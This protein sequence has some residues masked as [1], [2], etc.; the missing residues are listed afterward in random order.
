MPFGDISNKENAF[1]GHALKKKEAAREK[2]FENAFTKA[3]QLSEK[4]WI[5][6]FYMSARYHFGLVNYYFF[7][8][9]THR[10]KLKT[11]KLQFSVLGS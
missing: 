6:W 4:V 10:W 1:E 8:F 7:F 3:P 2:E 5:T 11:R 9:I